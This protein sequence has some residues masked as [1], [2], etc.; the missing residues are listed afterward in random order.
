MMHLCMRINEDGS[1]TPL[2]LDQERIH[3]VLDE[4]TFVGAIPELCCVALASS[5][6]TGSPNRHA[7]QGLI[8]DDVRGPIYL[9]G[10]DVEGE[11]IDLDIVSGPPAEDLVSAS[12]FTNFFLKCEKEQDARGFDF[13]DSLLLFVDMRTVVY[14]NRQ[15]VRLPSMVRGR[16]Q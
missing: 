1:F 2:E 11:A 15:S 16:H 14:R 5:T 3:F 4:P 7:L 12:V 10:S 6:C 13:G 9:V 8:D